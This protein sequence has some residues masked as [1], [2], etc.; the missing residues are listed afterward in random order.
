[1]RQ[2][3]DRKARRV[4]NEHLSNKHGCYLQMRNPKDQFQGSSSKALTD[5][6]LNRLACL[7]RSTLVY[8]EAVI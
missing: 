5:T 1:M 4:G 2:R 3:R 7:N 8:R 6:G